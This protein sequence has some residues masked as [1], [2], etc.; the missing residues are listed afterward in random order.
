MNLKKTYLK[1]LKAHAQSKLRKAHK[2]YDKVLR[3][4]L[5]MSDERR[6]TKVSRDL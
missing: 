2:L 1:L 4:Q 5:E 6:K 3:L